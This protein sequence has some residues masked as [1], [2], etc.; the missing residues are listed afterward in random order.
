MLPAGQP[1]LTVGFFVQIKQ[2]SPQQRGH[3][4]PSGQSEFLLHLISSLSGQSLLLTQVA[5]SFA[6]ATKEKSNKK[7]VE[8]NV[9]DPPFEDPLYPSHDLL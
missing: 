2:C 1:S 8:A 9:I 6:L 4:D 3:V 7:T 5:Q